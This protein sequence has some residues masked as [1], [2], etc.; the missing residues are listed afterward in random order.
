[1]PENINNTKSIVTATI[2]VR[3]VD[4]KRGFIND[5]Q[6]GAMRLFQKRSD[7]M[8]CRSLPCETDAMAIASD[9]V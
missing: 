8:W 3:T 5:A 2:Q 4:P 7:S 6:F 9:L 1:M